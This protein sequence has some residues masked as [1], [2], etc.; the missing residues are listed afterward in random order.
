MS[1]KQLYE[2]T[3]GYLYQALRNRLG[4]DSGLV[5]PT[6]TKA[7]LKQMIASLYAHAEQMDYDYLNLLDQYNEAIDKLTEKER[8]ERTNGIKADNLQR[9]VDQQSEVAAEIFQVTKIMQRLLREI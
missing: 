2:M 9:R 3:G 4:A 1:G 7:Q 8:E 6:Y 5:P